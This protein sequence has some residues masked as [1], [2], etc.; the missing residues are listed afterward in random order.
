MFKVPLLPRKLAFA[1]RDLQHSDP[2][3][4]LS[5]VVDL[6]RGG[7]SEEHARR[8]ELLRG[9]L[10]D[11][12]PGVIA[13]AVFAL[14]DLEARAAEPSIRRLLTHPEIGVRRA[15]L[16]A[17]GEL[18]SSDDTELIADVRAF[19]GARDPGVRYQAL[20]A[21][22]RLGAED[23]KE[24]LIDSCRDEDG[25][26]RELA[27]RLIDEGLFDGRFEITP[28]IEATLLQMA[29]DEAFG[30]RAVAQLCALS[31]GIGGP[32]DAIVALVERSRR[33]KEPHDEQRAIELAGRNRLEAA[34]PGLAR[35]ALGR[36]GFSTD[37]FRTLA[38]VSLAAFDDPK[39]VARV[40]SALRSKK[41]PERALAIVAIGQQRVLRFRDELVDRPGD[42]ELMRELLVQARTELG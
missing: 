15:S 17:L 38:A 32:L 31:Y 12:H 7:S 6:G 23:V 4:R 28:S 19:L 29:E 37:P 40:R 2:A 27:V 18:G 9:V 5:A 42:D 26:V 11:A 20:G 35:R 39:A 30:A 13:R 24:L 3:V 14:A 1:Q 25:E 10:S 33:P 21:L 34:R 16:V 41:K 8:V 22:F 36:W